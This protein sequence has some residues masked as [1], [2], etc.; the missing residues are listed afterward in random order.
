MN[1]R[2]IEPGESIGA[3]R[4]ETVACI[5]VYAG[6][7]LL[8]KCLESVFAHTPASVPI[9][10]FDDA[11]PDERSQEYARG[12]ADVADDR[13][14]FYL[15]RERN[16][17]FPANVNGA[18]AAAAPADVVL[19]NSDCLQKNTRADISSPSWALRAAT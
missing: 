10:I 14:L 15:R 5:P 13:E 17:G 19:L 4:G 12:L 7:E 3:R 18:F 16:V 1:V 6:H 2:W 11:S 8:V 9:M